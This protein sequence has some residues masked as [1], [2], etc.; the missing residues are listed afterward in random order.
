MNALK[1]SLHDVVVIIK[2]SGK[3]GSF[4]VDSELSSRG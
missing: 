1:R 3:F 4:Y 2:I